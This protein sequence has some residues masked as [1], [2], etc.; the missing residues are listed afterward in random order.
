[1]LTYYRDVLHDQGF[2]VLAATSVADAKQLYD[3]NRATVCGMISDGQVIG[4]ETGDAFVEHV[5]KIGFTGPII[6]ASM[7]S[8]LKEAFLRAGATAFTTE[9][10]K[11]MP[12]LLQLLPTQGA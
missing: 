7:S 1:M 3:Q 4:I 10:D 9:K 6:A 11:A 8:G 12:M 2:Q 5:R